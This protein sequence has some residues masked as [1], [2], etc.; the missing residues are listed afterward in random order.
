MSVA[1]AFA[2]INEP[3][4]SH[5]TDDFDIEAIIS[6]DMRSA[7]KCD[8]IIKVMIMKLDYTVTYEQS[9]D[10]EENDHLSDEKL[11]ICDPSEQT[12]KEMF[13]DKETKHADM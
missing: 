3:T 7:E 10:V 1:E 5:V 9:G 2:G 13:R 11:T 4:T 6:D 8:N 12:Q